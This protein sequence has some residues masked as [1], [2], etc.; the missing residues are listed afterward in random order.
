L[1]KGETREWSIPRT[2]YSPRDLLVAGKQ[3]AL[4]L[5]ANGSIVSVGDAGPV[6][7]IPDFGYEIVCALIRHPQGVYVVDELGAIHTSKHVTPVHSPYYRFDN[8]IID[9]HRTSRGKWVYLTKEG[10]VFTFD[11]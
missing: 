10:K 11:E 1:R 2:A 6:E 5:Y 8:W 4:V 3:G 7:G 9:A